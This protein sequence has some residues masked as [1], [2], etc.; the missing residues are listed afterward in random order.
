MLPNIL[1]VRD[2]H[3]GCIARMVTRKMAIFCCTRTFPGVFYASSV[4]ATD[5][6]PVSLRDGDDNTNVAL[7]YLHYCV[8]GGDADIPFST[9][10]S[11]YQM[12]VPLHVKK[13]N[14]EVY[15]CSQSI[16][17]S[18]AANGTGT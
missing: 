17:W 12:H 2:L 16:A 13:T 10:D 11:V 4:P 5:T 8:S 18:L 15:P 1:Q 6:R 14:I 9:S 7:A 3:G